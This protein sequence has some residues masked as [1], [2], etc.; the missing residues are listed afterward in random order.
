MAISVPLVLEYEAALLRHVDATELNEDDMRNVVDYICSVAKQQPIFFLWRPLLKD[1]H[2]DMVA[3][4]AVAAGCDALVTHNRRDF[5]AAA[6][7]GLR[8]ITP[9]EFL[10]EIGRSR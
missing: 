6:S 5:D 4:V 2:D 10:D 3:E 8:V 9:N 1:P 7:L